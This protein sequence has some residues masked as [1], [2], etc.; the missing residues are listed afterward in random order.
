MANDG[1]ELARDALRDLA[2]QQNGLFTR[3]Q[4]LESGVTLA[5]VNNYIGHGRV[6]RVAHGIYRYPHLPGGEFESFQVALLRTGDPDAILSHETALAIWDVS[7]ANPSRYHVTVPVARRIRRSDNDLY[8]IHEET[9]TPEQWT[10]WEL[11][12]VATL[13]TAI[14]QCITAG[15]PAYLLRQ[16][17]TQGARTGAVTKDL[18]HQLTAAMETR[19][20]PAR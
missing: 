17:I 14:R 5:A 3:R 1:R 13:P 18:E 6:E 8:V 15:T 7:D 19:D 20:N 12:P 2:E 4:A 11:M 10:W 16:A 9:L